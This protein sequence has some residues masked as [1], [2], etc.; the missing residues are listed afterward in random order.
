MGKQSRNQK[1]K[2][3]KK[4][5]GSK[6]KENGRVENNKRATVKANSK[7][8]LSSKEQ[9]KHQARVQ[10]K[11]KQT[12]A[13]TRKRV[14][15]M[16]GPPKIVG[17]V[18]LGSKANPGKF[19]QLFVENVTDM[20][21]EETQYTFVLEKF[22]Q[23]IT[24][25]EAKRTIQ[26]VLDVA[27]V[28]D[29]LIL[30]M[31]WS[32][33]ID[34]LGSEFISLVSS[35]GLPSIVP[36]LQGLEQVDIKHRHE[37]RKMFSK[38]M[39]TQFPDQPK[40]H[41]ADTKQ[42]IDKLH[43]CIC[44]CKL[45]EVHWR[46]SRPYMLVHK[47]S[48][49]PSQTQEKTGTLCVR[50]Y[51]R[52]QNMSANQL[53]HLVNFGTFQIEK[54]TATQ[55]PFAAKRRTNEMEAEHETVLHTPEPDKQESL[56]SEQAIDT[57]AGEQTWP[58][59][60][61]LAQAEM[62]AREMDMDGENTTTG[63]KR[64]KRVPKGFSDY[65]A[66]WIPDDQSDE[67]GF[68]DDDSDESEGESDEEMKENTEDQAMDMHTEDIPASDNESEEE[69]AADANKK[70]EEEPYADEM[71]TEQEVDVQRKQEVE[72]RRQ[73]D[74]DDEF[75]DEVD[76]PMNQP[77]RIRFQKYRGLK[78]FRNSPWD[79]KESLPQDYARIF[80]FQNFVKT[81]KGIQSHL[82][83]FPVQT[84]QYVSIYISNVPE[85][86]QEKAKEEGNVLL[87]GLLPHE[88][89]MSL[90]NFVIQPTQ[91]YTK[92]IRSKSKL[93]VQCGFRSYYCNPVFSQNNTRC[94]KNKLDRFLKTGCFS[95]GSFFGHITFLP[96]PVLVFSVDEETGKQTLIATGSLQ[97]VDPDRI[98][99]KRIILSGFPLKVHKKTA[100]VRFMFFNPE[101][102][103]W[104]KPIEIHT[105][106]GLTGHIKES[107][108]THGHMKCQFSDVM[109]GQ[110]TICMSLY[111]RVF[112]K[113][114]TQLKTLLPNQ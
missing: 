20:Q 63:G 37:N 13:L 29:V 71:L 40:L 11:L 14:G 31:D 108:G 91:N 98:I 33:G 106:N 69:M 112:P 55:D 6:N 99:L 93:L 62:E 9:R 84:D 24:T 39:E 78:S 4:K 23:R 42:E 102:I 54:I 72:L 114:T 50:G 51:L 7:S 34:E 43:R 28:S 17:V 104:F 1:N 2:P 15:T 76:T 45:R 19:K 73:A 49:T 44:D 79:P 107:L 10:R 21:S 25:I 56:V 113:W 66:A 75:P 89:K 27:K 38:H 30:L 36:V 110:D 12:T 26:S 82:S 60:E 100:V 80:Q 46:H 88:N 58:T 65:Q 47:W 103:N 67:E 101:D 8:G 97:S 92:P 94:D 53:V 70:Q 64:R 95:V 18:C 61:E 86:F 57:M 59:E 32:E 3:F 41:T 105:K 96:V 48:Y 77:A 74:E 68:S 87:F 5:G 85:A 22:K 111:K 35:Q 90:L 109:K 81:Q 52:G 83:D 16:Q